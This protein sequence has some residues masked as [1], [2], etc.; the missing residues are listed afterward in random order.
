[1]VDVLDQPGWHKFR[2]NNNTSSVH[3]PKPNRTAI[4]TVTARPI[5][6]RRRMCRSALVNP[7]R[8]A[9][10]GCAASSVLSGPSS[11]NLNLAA[12][13]VCDEAIQLLGGYGFSR[14]Y[15]VERVYRDLRVLRIYEGASEIHR[16]MIARQ[17]LA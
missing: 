16:N 1:M 9:R 8:T 12:K 10:T 6:G 17:L 7:W 3:R 2:N 5:V 11:V 14:E 13:F 15:P 4:T